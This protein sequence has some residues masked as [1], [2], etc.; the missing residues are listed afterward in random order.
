MNST[1]FTRLSSKPR[2][3]ELHP[4]VWHSLQAH[5]VK[6]S[7][8]NS[9]HHCLSHLACSKQIKNAKPN[10]RLK[11]GIICLLQV[12]ARQTGIHEPC[13]AQNDA[14]NRLLA[15]SLLHAVAKVAG[16][17]RNSTGTALRSLCI[18]L[19]A[20][21]LREHRCPP[22]CGLDAA[23]PGLRQRLPPQ[24]KKTPASPATLTLYT[25]R[26]PTKCSR[27]R[28]YQAIKQTKTQRTSRS[29]SSPTN[30]AKQNKQTNK[31]NKQ[32]VNQSNKR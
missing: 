29:T 19:G 12:A 13:L 1:K 25:S 9:S 22:D 8:T 14:A 7:D 20:Q 30:V 4:K 28:K 27:R 32:A 10:M 18:Q 17:A 16:R 15:T 24:A 21:W 23:T 6:L 3:N 2:A 5:S 26:T 31:Q 11:A